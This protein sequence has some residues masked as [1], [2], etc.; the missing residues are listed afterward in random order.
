MAWVSATN[1]VTIRI[2]NFSGSPVNPGSLTFNGTLAVYNL[3]GSSTINFS[4]IADGVCASNTFSLTGVAAGD[5][6]IA[7]WPSTIEAGL[8]GG[9]VATATDTVEV[10]LC[11]FSGSSLDPASQSFGA[12]IAK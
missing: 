1:T 6:V 10:R 12:S 11:N 2:F 4:S 8:L 5:P 7:K 3:S 9:M